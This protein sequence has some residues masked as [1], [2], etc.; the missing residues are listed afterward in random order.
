MK[1]ERNV[2]NRHASERGK[3]SRALLSTGA[4]LVAACSLQDLEY[5]SDGRDGGLSGSLNSSGA[6]GNAGNGGSGSSNGGN[7]GSGSGGVSGEGAGG[8]AATG[9]GGSGGTTGGG[10][11]GGS[12]GTAPVNYGGSA[13]Y[14]GELGDGGPDGNLVANPGFEEG[15]DGWT[16]QGNPVL[17]WT[18]V[19][20]AAGTHCLRTSNRDAEWEGPAYS[21]KSAVVA[22]ATYH[23]SAYVRVSHPNQAIKFTTKE[24]CQGA[25]ENFSDITSGTATTSWRFFEGDFTVPTCTLTNFFVFFEQ[26]GRNV[27]IFLDE[28]RVVPVP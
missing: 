5:L 20:P 6:G 14:L 7:G 27:E 28:V 2:L 10:G 26:A 8:S 4:L 24:I 25:A 18:D 22:G 1:R 11:A 23:L 16:P 9:G 19:G 21:L 12:A 13:G 15:I 3:H 17:T